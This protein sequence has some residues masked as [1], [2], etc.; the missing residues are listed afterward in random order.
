MN[1]KLECLMLA[2]TWV[3]KALLHPWLM[4]QIGS[5]LL[6]V[7][8]VLDTLLGAKDAPVELKDMILMVT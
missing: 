8:Y 7:Y 4:V 6:S 2:I 5:D 3:E 1:E